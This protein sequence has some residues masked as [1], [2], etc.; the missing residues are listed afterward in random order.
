MADPVAATPIGPGEISS[1][2][3]RRLGV[4]EQTPECGTEV[5]LRVVGRRRQPHHA[6][7]CDGRER[8]CSERER[9]SPD[10]D[11]A[12][13]NPRDCRPCDRD[14]DQ[15][16][17]DPRPQREVEPALTEDARRREH[18]RDE[19]HSENSVE[20][21]ERLVSESQRNG[22]GCEPRRKDEQPG[23]NGTVR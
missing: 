12:R 16:R 1:I 21:D 13:S 5:L 22:E 20:S 8:D 3:E 23:P 2:F 17:G 15:R 4:G 6:E 19:R 14:E 7:R 10:C 9:T 18:R 11:V